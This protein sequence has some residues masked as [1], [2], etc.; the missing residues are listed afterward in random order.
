MQAKILVTFENST[1]K[2]RTYCNHLI[3]HDVKTQTFLL[4]H[5]K[6]TRL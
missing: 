6:G 2:L 1:T 5:R 3:L 4:S